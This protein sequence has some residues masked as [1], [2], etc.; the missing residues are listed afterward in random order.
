M[1]RPLHTL[2]PISRAVDRDAA[3]VPDARCVACHE[4]DLKRVVTQRGMRI[5]H[6]SCSAGVS[7]TDCHS[8]VAH[9][10]AIR[11]VRS[12]DMDTCLDCHMTANN[13]ACDLCH[14]GKVASDRVKFAEFAVTHGPKWKNTHAMGDTSTCS[15][16][17]KAGD[18]AEC[19]GVG[20]PHEA[21]YVDL[22]SSYA[23]QVDERCGS[24]HSDAPLSV[25][26]AP[27]VRT[28]F[29]RVNRECQRLPHHTPSSIT[30]G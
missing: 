18:C 27:I 3:A 23:G 20:V 15:V 14:D 9:G 22:H 13:V 25:R 19:H 8:A 10:T 29:A 5:N 4:A 26:T 24:C 11:W 17:H 1:K 6:Q 30:G 16:C 21:N 7:C 28:T 12:Y 2:L